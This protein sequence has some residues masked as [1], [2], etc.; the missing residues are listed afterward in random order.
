MA[1]IQDKWSMSLWLSVC[2]S[3]SSGERGTVQGIYW[4]DLYKL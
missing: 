4:N 1:A 3:G 2:V